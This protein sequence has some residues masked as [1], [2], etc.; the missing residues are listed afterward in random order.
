MPNALVKIF[1]IFTR[2]ADSSA[3][4]DPESESLQ[5]DS[6]VSEVWLYPDSEE[7]MK[8]T[9]MEARKIVQPVF[10]IG[11]RLSDSV[12]Y[13]DNNSPD[14]SIFENSPYTLSRLQCQIEIEDDR[15]VLRDMGSRLGTRLG[16]K[17]LRSNFRESSSLV[18]PKGSHS[19]ILGNRD[20]PFRFRL[21]VT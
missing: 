14:L 2:S 7:L 13:S 9:V 1:K 11:R 8:Q 18:V 19:L 21:V 15:V 16:Q 5:P 6:G 20:G 10:R 12:A 3:E 4:T 17:R